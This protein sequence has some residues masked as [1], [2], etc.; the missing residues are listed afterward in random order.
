MKAILSSADIYK[1]SMLWEMEGKHRRISRLSRT[2][3][4]GLCSGRETLSQTRWKRWELATEYLGSLHGLFP[5]FLWKQKQRRHR[6]QKFKDDSRES[7]SKELL[8]SLKIHIMPWR[9]QK[10]QVN[11]KGKESCLPSQSMEQMIPTRY[12]KETRSHQAAEHPLTYE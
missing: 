7:F 10:D 2:R 3:F 12:H 1:P 11:R 6:K 9:K 5:N 4:S 8:Q